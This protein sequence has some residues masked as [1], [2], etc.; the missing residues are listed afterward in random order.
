[1]ADLAGNAV[2]A[3]PGLAVDDDAAAHACTQRQK[4]AGMQPAADARDA[5]GK[6][7]DRRVV[8]N[9]DGQVHIFLKLTA[10][11]DIIPAQI[12]AEDD[13]SRHVVRQARD[14][15]AH[16]ADIIEGQS[17]FFKRLQAAHSHVPRYILV[18]TG[19]QRGRLS[20]GDHMALIVR[21]PCLDVGA[22]QINSDIMHS[23]ALPSQT[24]SDKFIM[25]LSRR[26][27]SLAAEYPI[28]FKL[29]LRAATSMMMARLRPGRTGITR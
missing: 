26:S 19:R 1:M 9:E 21:H 20:L 27:S 23:P 18:G 14:A 22:A 15:D 11:G 7:R 12:G 17:A 24:S 8:I 28:F 13:V 5:L 25:A 6:A 29:K 16:T 2:R 3:G 4:H 10:Q